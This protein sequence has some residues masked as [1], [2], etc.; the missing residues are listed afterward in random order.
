MCDG[1]CY[2]PDSPYTMLGV[3]CGG[4]P[5]NDPPACPG[6]A[7]YQQTLQELH[8][9]MTVLRSRHKRLMS[10]MVLLQ[11]V[12]QDSMIEFGA[13]LHICRSRREEFACED[14]RDG[15]GDHD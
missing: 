13:C 5:D 10:D 15:V 12:M 1:S 3:D 8:R 2:S 6:C 4:A 7:G 9:E 14:I 11:R